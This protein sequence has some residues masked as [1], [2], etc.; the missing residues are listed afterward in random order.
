MN[1]HAAHSR[2]RAVHGRPAPRWRWL[3]TVIGVL[4]ALL[5]LVEVGVPEGAPR[6]I[7]QTLVVLAIVVVMALWVRANRA[8]LNVARERHIWPVDVLVPAVVVYR[9]KGGVKRGRRRR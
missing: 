9:H 5:G 2:S 1:T 3:Y 4:A 7:L 8:A 6:R